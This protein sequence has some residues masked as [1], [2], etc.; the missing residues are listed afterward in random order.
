VPTERRT[1]DPRGHAFFDLDMPS[2]KFALRFVTPK[3][4]KA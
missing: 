2:G 4:G 3:Q 1:D